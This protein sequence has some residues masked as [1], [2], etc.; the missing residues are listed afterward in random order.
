[1][2]QDTNG[3]DQARFT[4][5]EKQILKLTERAWNLFLEI[6]E[7]YM[8]ERKDMERKIHEVQRMIISR[9]GFRIN[10]EMLNHEK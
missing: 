1:M 6:P 7:Q 9:P 5:K 4:K 3:Y 2:E 10:R 8:G